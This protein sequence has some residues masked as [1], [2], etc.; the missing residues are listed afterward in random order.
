MSNGESVT[1]IGVPPEAGILHSEP[2][3][4]RL[5]EKRISRPSPV[6]LRPRMAAPSKVRRCGS[7]PPT[8]TR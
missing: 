7:P 1:S 5:E 2:F 4:S 6:Q 8:G 3:A